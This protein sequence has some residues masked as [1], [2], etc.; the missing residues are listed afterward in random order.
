MANEKAPPPNYS[1][2]I[3]TLP[4]WSIVLTFIFFF[5]SVFGSVGILFFA[6]TVKQH[7]EHKVITTADDYSKILKGQDQFTIQT[8]RLVKSNQEVT[9]SLLFRENENFVSGLNK[10]DLKLN[11]LSIEGSNDDTTFHPIVSEKFTIQRALQCGTSADY[12]GKSYFCAPVIVYRERYI[13]YPTYRIKVQIENLDVS[14]LLRSDTLFYRLETIRSDFTTFESVM[15]YLYAA[16][17]IIIFIFYSF[18]LLKYQTFRY[19]KTEQKWILF[20]LISLILFNNPLFIGEWLAN[21]WILPFLNIIFQSTF[22]SFFLLFLMVITASA[23]THPKLRTVNFYI[24]KS[25]FT[26][27]FWCCLTVSLLFERYETFSDRLMYSYLIDAPLFGIIR[28]GVIGLGGLMLLYIFYQ[29]F[30]TLGGNDFIQLAENLNNTQPLNQELKDKLA[31]NIIS[32][33]NTNQSSVRFKYFFIL[34]FLVL[35]VLGANMFSFLIL[36]TSDNAVQYLGVFPLLN[37]YCIML[38]IYFL[39]SLKVDMK[40][41]SQSYITNQMF[42]TNTTKA[43]AVNETASNSENSGIVIDLGDDEDD[44]GE[45]LI[46]R[47]E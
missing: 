30:K 9:I 36:N 2:L 8:S 14:S 5:L 34:T 13:S 20:L 39:P 23:N 37:F 33:S 31:M 3:D 44:D 25:I 45:D 26:L 40:D 38:A 17:S 11:I 29:I 21:D 10:K 16:I 15:R 4:S 22:I 28:I 6:P 42:S 24:W 43:P 46:I 7:I 41:T 1:V 27:L 19:A 35:V 18:I 47:E 12:N 32:Y